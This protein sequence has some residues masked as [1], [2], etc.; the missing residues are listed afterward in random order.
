M[1]EKK[2]AHVVQFEPGNSEHG[3]VGGF[4]WSYDKDLIERRFL[5]LMTEDAGYIVRRWSVEVDVEGGRDAVQS[6]IEALLETGAIGLPKQELSSMSPRDAV[7]DLAKL[8]IL[9][10]K[11]KDDTLWAH[12]FRAIGRE[13]DPVMKEITD[14]RIE[15]ASDMDRIRAKFGI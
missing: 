9:G 15:L 12:Y 6:N 1:T 14:R 5:R 13:D 4:D 11:F 7:D 8:A 2:T 10:I 3:G